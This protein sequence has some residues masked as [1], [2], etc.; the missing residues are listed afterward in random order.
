MTQNWEEVIQEIVSSYKTFAYDVLEIHFLCSHLD[1]FPKNL[2]VVSDD[3]GRA[4]SKI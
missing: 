2:G 3:H 4:C 1:F